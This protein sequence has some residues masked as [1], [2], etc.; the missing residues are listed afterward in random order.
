MGKANISELIVVGRFSRRVFIETTTH[1]DIPDY[2][3]DEEKSYEGGRWYGAC[4]S[5]TSRNNAG[6]IERGSGL[7]QWLW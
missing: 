7:N 5:V 3:G 2:F 6:V 4:C 1:H